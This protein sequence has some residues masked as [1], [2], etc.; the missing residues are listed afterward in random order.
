MRVFALY[1]PEKLPEGGDSRFHP[2]SGTCPDS[3]SG[4]SIPYFRIDFN[5]L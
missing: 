2:T 3:D 5:C 1:L 4:I